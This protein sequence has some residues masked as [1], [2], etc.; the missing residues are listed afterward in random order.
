MKRKKLLLRML[1]FAVV[2]IMAEN[3]LASPYAEGEQSG[4]LQIGPNNYSGRI[5]ASMFDKFNEGVIYAGSVGGLYVSVNYGKNWQEIPVGD[6]V[7]NI[8][9]ITQGPDGRLYVAT[10]EGYYTKMIHN[11]NPIGYSN[12][13]SGSISNG[14]F[15]Q[16]EI[17]TK[18]WAKNFTGPKAD[19]LKYDY[20]AK[21][22]GFTVMG[23]TK[24]SSKYALSDE[25]AYVN[26]ILC[27]DSILYIGTKNGGLKY[28]QDITN[29][30]ASF[31]NITI[32]GNSS[33]NVYDLCANSQGKIAIAYE[34]TVAVGKG[35]NFKVIF[36]SDADEG[37]ALSAWGM[38][39]IKLTFADKNPNDLFIFVSADLT[40]SPSS[41][42][43]PDFNGFI[44]GIYRP[45]FKK[46][47]GGTLDENTDIES[48]QPITSNWFNI[49]TSSMAGIAGTSLGYGQSI[50]VDDRRAEEIVYLGGNSIL[51]GQDLNHEGRFTFN[52][53]TS[54]TSEDTS[55]VNIGINIHNIL[56]MPKPTDREMTAY[57]SLFLFVTSDMGAFRYEYDSVIGSLRWWPCSLGMD[58]L[59]T[60]KVS[61]TADGS[62]LA[63]TQS[64][65]IVYIP[66]VTD[67]T[68]RGNKIWS[69]NNPNYPF[70]S[71]ITTSAEKFQNTTFTGSG[72]NASAIHKTTPSIRKPILLSRPG[73]NLTRTY[74]NAGDFD[75]INDQTWTYGSKDL[76]TFLSASVAENAIFDPFNTPTAFWESFDFQGVIDSVEME[77]NDYTQIKRNGQT[78]TCRNGQDILVGDTI[79]VQSNNVDYPFFHIMSKTDT[80]GISKAYDTTT[81]VLGNDDTIL[82]KNANM[83][84][85]IPQPIQARVLIATNTGAFIC[86]KVLDFSKTI[87]PNAAMENRWGNLTWVKLYSTGPASSEDDISTMNNRIHAVALTQNGN[88]AFLAIDKYSDFDTY[89]NTELVRVDGLNDVNVGDDKIFRGNNVDISKFTNAVIATFSR[90]ISSIACD[91]KNS[92]NMVVTFESTTSTDANVKQTTNALA[93]TVVFTDISLNIDR[94]NNVVTNDKP[95]FTALYEGINS[96][97]STPSGRLYVGSDDGIYYREG[98]QWISDNSKMPNVSVFHLWQ[99]TKKLPKWVFYS[100]TGDN[101][102]LTTFEATKNTGVIYAATYGK[103][104][105]VNNDFK[106]TNAIQSNVSLTNIMKD[107]ENE[108]LRIYPN[109]AVNEATITYT[110]DVADNVEFRM[111]DMNGREVSSFNSGMQSKGNHLQSID[112]SRL[113]RGIYMIRMITK[114]SSKSAK[115]VVK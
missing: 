72:V 73:T 54:P 89:N 82:F 52:Q 16:T 90:P 7:Q 101:A 26:D 58:N 8:T 112:V 115:L 35:N 21:N 103:G 24:P 42:Y 93:S 46:I 64:N 59:Q 51:L 68:K 45:Y 100:Y 70:S 12:Q 36:N 67:S 29:P 62:V 66:T 1:F 108:S 25:W 2:S 86:G 96:G 33:F 56:P 110:I 13:M 9:A 15:M 85:K 78:L 114:N 53:I 97:K 50:Y 10:G 32:N 79:L 55:G 18:S 92:N 81:Y 71:N 102:E 80:M 57:D 63:A 27:Q 5:R 34:G 30:N 22:F 47:K 6:A 19:S 104:V 38:S 75:A 4:W 77:L 109:P 61:A 94:N 76:Q 3:V 113:Q 84:I 107:I 14:I 20:I 41:K 43:Q 83:K 40:K 106:D 87:N 88:S 98:D 95:V 60:Y 105:W 74:S 37:N 49:V 111:Y 11:E 23:A 99:Q 39:R 48:L 65:A 91:P 28:T 44:Y 69:V 31:S 17:V